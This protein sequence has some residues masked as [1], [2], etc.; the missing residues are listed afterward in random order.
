MTSP[1][2]SADHPY[3][4]AAKQFSVQL[5]KAMAARRKRP[6]HV[7]KAANGGFSYYLFHSWE[8]GDS[9]PK[10]ETALLLASILEW[11]SLGGIVRAARTRVCERPGCGKTFVTESGRVRMYC[12]ARCRQ[13]VHEYYK[14]RHQDR[15]SLT[16]LEA[17][18]RAAEQEAK[19]DHQELGEHRSA[20]AAMCRDCEPEGYC[21]T[22]AC[23]LRLVSPLP[24]ARVRIESRDKR[25]RRPE[26]HRWGPSKKKVAVI[27]GE[28]ARSA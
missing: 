2:Y 16:D 3:F 19:A 8:K 25:L 15:K 1:A 7:F 11:P 13:I 12:G 17:A 9:L 24:L 23:P 27:A 26:H 22:P 5:P 14:G 28:E 4:T 18:A 6:F 21:R 10:L 20:V